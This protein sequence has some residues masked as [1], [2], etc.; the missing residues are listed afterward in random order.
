MQVSKSI[1]NTNAGYN[2]SDQLVRSGTS[3]ALNYG[4]AQGAES[5]KDFIHKLRIVQKELRET[6]VCLTMLLRAELVNNQFLCQ[7]AKQECSELI[8]IITSSITTS[9]KGLNDM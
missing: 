3:V 6:K 1:V 8:A 9:Q 2:L 5:R 7:E 4:E